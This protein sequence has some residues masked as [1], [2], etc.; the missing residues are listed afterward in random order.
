MTI[1]S[2]PTWLVLFWNISD[3]GP[4]R[5]E[6]F[7][8]RKVLSLFCI[9]NC[10]RSVNWTIVSLDPFPLSSSGT[11]ICWIDVGRF[12]SPVCCDRLLKVLDVNVGF[13]SLVPQPYVDCGNCQS[14][15]NTYHWMQV[16][17]IRGH[18]LRRVIL[19]VLQ[20][21]GVKS[22]IYT[23]QIRTNTS[24]KAFNE[25]MHWSLSAGAP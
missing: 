22:T 18:V 8:L 23:A 4:I 7:N 20:W 3:I 10:W 2:A 11:T 17:L 25:W 6:F 15:L 12:W 19:G 13:V 5:D 14:P 16:P 9:V 21:K 1:N 24:E